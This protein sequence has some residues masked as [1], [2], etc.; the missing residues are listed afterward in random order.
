MRI[1]D[2]SSDVCSSDLAERARRRLR[3]HADADVHR[4]IIAQRRKAAVHFG[5]RALRPG[6]PVR[7][8]WP[9]ALV[10][11]G[12]VERD[13]PRILNRPSLV[14]PRG[15]LPGRRNTATIDRPDER[16]GRKKGDRT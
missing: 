2:W 9:H 5:H 14:E 7:I 16:R 1:S 6:A 15:D 4:A 11:V 3:G 12:K 8:A 10:A 13:A